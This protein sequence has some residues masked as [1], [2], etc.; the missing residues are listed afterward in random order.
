MRQNCRAWVYGLAPRLLLERGQLELH[1]DENPTTANIQRGTWLKVS[2]S[3]E[4]SRKLC[5]VRS[6]FPVSAR[7]LTNGLAMTSLMTS[8][9]EFWVRAPIFLL[10]CDSSSFESKREL[11]SNWPNSLPEQKQSGFKFGLF[12]TSSYLERLEVNTNISMNKPISN[13]SQQ[14]KSYLAKN[15]RGRKS[16][17]TLRAD[18]FWP[19]SWTWARSSSTWSDSRDPPFWLAVPAAAA[20]ALAVLAALAGAALGLRR[21]R[22]APVLHAFDRKLGQVPRSAQCRCKWLLV[23]RRQW[24]TRVRLPVLLRA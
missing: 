13:K 2:K 24:Q 11:E 4:F 16:A 9:E 22:Q 8:S 14:W 18:C 6:T 20:A 19:E 23:L 17:S 15:S 12:E 21:R 10:T 5:T 3:S 7:M 1:Y